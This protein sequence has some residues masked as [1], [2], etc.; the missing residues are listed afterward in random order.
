MKRPA[1]P[2]FRPSMTR[3]ELARTHY[4][5]MA[6]NLRG[7]EFD[8]RWGMEGTDRIP[9]A[10]ADIAMEPYS[11]F[12]ERLTLRI[13]EDVLRFFRALG[14]GY[15]THMNRVLRTYMLARLAGVVQGAEREKPA[16]LLA[17]EFAVDTIAYMDLFSRR[18]AMQKE[19]PET[20]AMDGE[21]N[22]MEDKLRWIQREMTRAE[23]AFNVAA[24]GD[25]VEEE[26]GS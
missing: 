16:P 19:G 24:F 18:R 5:H 7:L 4:N 3:L 2:P 21:L 20:E 11:P 23:E 8:L 17:E 10:W 14:Q 6:T 15:L 13:D 25:P 9:A 22:R 1:P 12:K 26:G